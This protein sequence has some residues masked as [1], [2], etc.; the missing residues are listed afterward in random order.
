MQDLLDG[1]GS[2]RSDD[3]TTALVPKPETARQ[4]KNRL[5]KTLRN[6]KSSLNTVREKGVDGLVAILN[7]NLLTI[8]QLSESQIEELVG[9]TFSKL[10]RKNPHRRDSY[11][12]FVKIFNELSETA[13]KVVGNC[14]FKFLKS[15][16]IGFDS[17]SIP[18]AVVIA[19]AEKIA[20]A[21]PDVKANWFQRKWYA[22]SNKVAHN[23]I[24]IRLGTSNFTGEQICTLLN[25][26]PAFFILGILSLL[27]DNV[28]EKL[29]P[30]LRKVVEAEHNVGKY[31]N[32]T[33]ALNNIKIQAFYGALRSKKVDDFATALRTIYNKPNEIEQLQILISRLVGLIGTSRFQGKYEDMMEL[34]LMR[35]AQLSDFREGLKLDPDVL[36]KC[37]GI[38]NRYILSKN[39]T[40]FF[41][42]QFA[43]G[44]T[45]RA[46]VRR[47]VPSFQAYKNLRAFS[48]RVS[49]SALLAAHATHDQIVRRV[50]SGECEM[51]DLLLR[52]VQENRF[53]EE[54]ARFLVNEGADMDRNDAMTGKSFLK[55]VLDGLGKNGSVLWDFYIQTKQRRDGN[56][57]SVLSKVV[58][59]Y[60]QYSIH[61]VLAVGGRGGI[62]AKGMAAGLLQTISGCSEAVRLLKDL[63][64]SVT[65]EI[66]AK[67]EAVN[68]MDPEHKKLLR[69]MLNQFPVVVAE[70]QVSIPSGSGFGGNDNNAA[71][72]P[73]GTGLDMETVQTSDPNADTAFEALKDILTN[74]KYRV[75]INALVI[76][77]GPKL[78]EL[79][80]E[81]IK[82]LT[83][84]TDLARA[85]FAAARKI[86]PGL[87]FIA[88]TSREELR[89]ARARQYAAECAEA[90]KT[91]AE[92]K[93]NKDKDDLMQFPEP[94]KSAAVVPTPVA[95]PAPAERSADEIAE[96]LKR[97]EEIVSNSFFSQVEEVAVLERRLSRTQLGYD[98]RTK[99]GTFKERAKDD[100][101]GKGLRNTRLGMLQRELRK[102]KLD[103]VN[104][105]LKQSGTA[106][107]NLTL[108]EKKQ[109]WKCDLEPGVREFLKKNGFSGA[110]FEEVPAAVAAAAPAVLP[111][112]A[113]AS[114]APVG[115]RAAMLISKLRELVAIDSLDKSLDKKQVNFIRNA[116]NELGA[117][118]GELSSFDC[119]I[120]F[121]RCT[122][123][124]FAADEF[125]AF[126]QAFMDKNLPV[127]VLAAAT[128]DLNQDDFSAAGVKPVKN[129]ER[130]VE[131]MHLRKLQG[132]RFL[133]GEEVHQDPSTMQKVF[134]CYAN[135]TNNAALKEVIRTYYLAE[136]EKKQPAVVEV[137]PAAVEEK[138]KATAEDVRGCLYAGNYQ[139]ATELLVELDETEKAN[140]E[141]IVK[142]DA[143]SLGI[144]QDAISK[145][146]AEFV[147]AW[148][149]IGKA[150]VNQFFGDN[151]AIFCAA[152]YKHKNV[153]KAL[154]DLG[155]NVMLKS[156]P[157]AY[158]INY[159][160]DF[161][162]PEIVALIEEAL[163]EEGLLQYFDKVL[164]ARSVDKVNYTIKKLGV[165]VTKLSQEVKEQFCSSA[166][167]LDSEAEDIL[168]E[169]GLGALLILNRCR[170]HRTNEIPS[171]LERGVMIDDE[172]A[173]GVSPL[174]WGL[175]Q[176]FMGVVEPLLEVGAKMTGKVYAYAAE[177]QHSRVIQFLREKYPVDTQFM[178]LCDQLSNDSATWQ[179][180]KDIPDLDA[181]KQHLT[182][183]QKQ[184]LEKLQ[185]VVEEATTFPRRTASQEQIVGAA[186]VHGLIGGGSPK[187][188]RKSEPEAEVVATSQSSV[189]P[190]N[191]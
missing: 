27:E 32:L 135:R 165:A 141:N 164:K 54:T 146:Y 90:E 29:V 185:P 20:A 85:T 88:A 158:L 47:T 150:D 6:I 102:N 92:Q 143:N 182:E 91:K 39:R 76:A 129:D 66:L 10:S 53:H 133:L 108:L 74:N 100:H 8:N 145:G 178:F 82:T 9:F 49:F 125:N 93:G 38:V 63:N 101:I 37:L 13:Q 73:R 31:P 172:K 7:G 176:G 116:M 134:E 21:C 112:V 124:P 97:L 62:L 43:S 187:E 191:N 174:I 152:Y 111:A 166:V 144:Y 151:P 25:K 64:V 138:P 163:P 89:R 156:V 61:H 123:L 48:P 16:R 33:T 177:Y 11:L 107:N 147:T 113:P 77:A 56:L 86:I 79:D 40:K 34:C 71:P 162:T 121:M 175:D 114:S 15:K 4:K 59:T 84:R 120:L 110:L 139:K 119:S 58:E 136:A 137:L 189:V 17:I 179:R 106:V 70:R 36:K 153:V 117:R 167:E 60:I 35:L 1:S 80:E 2:E 96:D 186:V 171:L 155:A 169:N 67:V 118:L 183:N 22:R 46:Y 109:V 75:D 140:F 160:I 3:E 12:A 105:L 81:L 50:R 103:E 126:M 154:L 188:E 132:V 41:A 23:L 24:I 157:G 52:T 115:D 94:P 83:E 51:Q 28:V 42:T 184:R 128:L 45:M 14:A 131:R 5:A 18:D 87:P 26:F 190:G 122:E 181:K 95:V 173:L 161:S 30:A 72:V 69:G 149:Q 78:K 65:P 55:L 148:I 168:I 142:K 57:N 68:N 180:L 159:A 99:L 98:L 127:Y 170:R 19:G 104:Y 44:H 130:A